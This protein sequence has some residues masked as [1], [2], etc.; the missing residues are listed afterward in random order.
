MSPGGD[1]VDPLVAVRRGCG[2]APNSLH[3]TVFSRPGW[4]TEPLEP[5]VDNETN[6]LITA[7]GVWS[8]SYLGFLAGSAAL[9]KAESRLL[10]GPSRASREDHHMYLFANRAVTPRI[11]EGPAGVWV[12]AGL[13]GGGCL[14]SLQRPSEF[15]R[16]PSRP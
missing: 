13:P 6:W 7:R 2:S 4:C 14:L 12:G 9:L 1:R 11:S 16:E 15:T 10:I 8:R 3:V 5:K